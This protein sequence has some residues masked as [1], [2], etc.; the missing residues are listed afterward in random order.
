[1]AVTQQENWE[2]LDY[3]EFQQKQTEPFQTWLKIRIND[4]ILTTVHPSE[5]QRKQLARHLACLNWIEAYLQDALVSLEQRVKPEPIESKSERQQ[6]TI[7]AIAP[8]QTEVSRTIAQTEAHASELIEDFEGWSAVR[9]SA[10]K[11][12]S[13]IAVAESRI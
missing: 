13:G 7:A 5:H 1:M 3:L 11:G 12:H 10:V 8:Q 2:G 6:Q 9:Q 4:K